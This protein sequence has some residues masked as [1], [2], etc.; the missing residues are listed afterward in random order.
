MCDFAGRI[1]TSQWALAVESVLHLHL[2]WRT[3]RSRLVRVTAEGSV[4]YFSSFEDLQIEQP[5]KEVQPNLI[6]TMY[7]HRADLEIIFGMIDKDHSGK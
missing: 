5:M 7:R 1:S 4:E 3:L 2:P 6:E